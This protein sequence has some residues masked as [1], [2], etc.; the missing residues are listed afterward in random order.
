MSSNIDTFPRQDPWGWIRSHQ[1]AVMLGAIALQMIV[2]GSMIVRQGWTLVTGEAILLRVTPVDPRDPLRGDYV[3]LRYG[4]SGLRPPGNSA[5]DEQRVGREIFVT[6][7]PEEDGKHWRGVSA[8]WTRP[9]S[10]RFIRGQV[11]NPWSNEFGIEA[12]FV[13]EGKGKEYEQARNAH[14][15]S[16]EIA[17]TAAGAATLKQLVLD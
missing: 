17:L 9:T 6:L 14:R 10:G 13:Q 2:L 12:Y 3:I 11:T 7:E 15:L 5:F 1:R 4:F 8:S 16:A